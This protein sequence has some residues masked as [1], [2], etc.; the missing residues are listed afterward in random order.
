M[1]KIAYCPT[2]KPFAN[3]IKTNQIQMIPMQSAAQVLSMLKNDEVDGVLIGRYAKNRELDSS[4]KRQIFKTGVT[5]IHSMKQGIDVK[6]LKRIPIKTYL[7]KNKI[8]QILP[9]LGK[10]EFYDSFESCLADG[11]DTPVLIDW[12]DYRD[13]FELLIPMNSSGK[14]PVFRA[15]VL[16]FKNIGK[17]IIDQIKASI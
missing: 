14:I 12:K 5:L 10:I 1:I 16:Y 3:K 15:P 8:K 17:E 7:P 6:Q 9:L 4:T 13:E 11:W 2:M